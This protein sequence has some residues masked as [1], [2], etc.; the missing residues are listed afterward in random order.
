[1]R[2]WVWVRS[3]VWVMVRRRMM[4]RVRGIRFG[5]VYRV[6]VRDSLGY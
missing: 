5:V 3:R 2:V 1:M 4:V 6:R